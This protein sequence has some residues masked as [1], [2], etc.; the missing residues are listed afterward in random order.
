LALNEARYLIV[1]GGLAGGSAVEAIR[2]RDREG[3]VVLVSDERHLPYDRV[4]LSK[5]YLMGKL[6]RE[7]LFLQEAEFY[8]QHNVEVLLGR[9]VQRLNVDARSALFSDGRELR[10]DRLL[11]S[12]GGRPRRLSIPGGNL[13]GIYY[14]RTIDDSDAIQAAMSK[15]HRAVVIGGGFIGC[16]IAAACAQKGLDA[17]IIEVG[18]S[19]LNAPIDAETAQ[20]ITQYFTERGVHVLTNEAAARFV[21]E[22]GRAVGVETKTGKEVL[23]DFVAVGIGVVPN[24]ELAQEAGLAV[25]NGVI[26]NEQLEVDN[27]GV[28]AAGDVARFYSPVF[29]KHLRLEHYDVAVKHGQ[30]AGA[31]M[32]GGQ[33]RFTELPYFFSFMF[34]LRTEVWGDATQRELVVRRGP[35]QLTDKG[36]FAQ[37]YLGQGR[38]QAYL[39]VNRPFK[40]NEAAK[41]LILS[42]QT[43]EDS[44]VLGN[45]SVDLETLAHSLPAR[46][47]AHA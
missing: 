21:E 42:R 3:R 11:L 31:N 38:I 13:P 30:V 20:W 39:S 46:P 28:Y 40:E 16:E 27:K 33:E 6:P 43:M 23:G 14:L 19:L 4:S 18:P 8:Q 10:F 5:E 9:R 37:F 32:A 34:K 17:T 7:S 2:S 41:K 1:G 29:A 47:G 26:V 12:T 45:E 36:G 44:S 35:L 15:A 25:D 22:N 24:V